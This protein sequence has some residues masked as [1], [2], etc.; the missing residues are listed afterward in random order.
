VSSANVQKSEVKHVQPLYSQLTRDLRDFCNDDYELIMA[1]TPTKSHE[2]NESGGG[3]ARS[4]TASAAPQ[5][6]SDTNTVHAQWRIPDALLAHNVHILPL[7]DGSSPPPHSLE[8]GQKHALIPI[9]VKVNDTLFTADGSLHTNFLTA[10]KE[11]LRD[12]ATSF[13]SPFPMFAVLAAKDEAALVIIFT[14][15]ESP[16]FEYSRVRTFNL[17]DENEFVAFAR[18]VRHAAALSM[19]AHYLEKKDCGIMDLKYE[20]AHLV[21]ILRMLGFTCSAINVATTVNEACASSPYTQLLELSKKGN[22]ASK[23]KVTGWNN[24]RMKCISILEGGGVFHASWTDDEE[25]EVHEI[26]K[27]KEGVKRMQDES[28]VFDHLKL[29][30]G[31]CD[32]THIVEKK[33]FGFAREARVLRLEPVGVGL[34][35]LCLCDEQKR[36]EYANIIARDIRIALD[37]LHAKGLAYNDLH[38]GNVLLSQDLQ[39][40]YLCDVESVRPLKE[41]WLE[42]KGQCL[43]KE[44]CTP[45]DEDVVRRYKTIVLKQP[46]VNEPTDEA[47]T[48]KVP[49]VE[50]AEEVMPAPKQKEIGNLSALFADRCWMHSPPPIRDVHEW[51]DYFTP[52]KEQD[53]KSLENILKLI[54]EKKGYSGFT[55]RISVVESARS[56]N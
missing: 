19:L 32:N 6:T 33:H 11:L 18:Y 51:K 39:S 46:T 30:D 53:E 1:Y 48:D 41:N 56:G 45:F 7:N 4:A 25:K 23:L 9:E 22:F 16:I 5:S 27:V 12:Y 47:P 52:T 55:T 49:T 3:D 43:N 20:P 17:T 36:N 14:T 38:I 31:T 8:C 29:A 50:V 35:R 40:A 10:I 34:H 26:F 2:A 54:K 37:T 13:L 24:V 28:D 42:F 21:Q 15:L 44:T